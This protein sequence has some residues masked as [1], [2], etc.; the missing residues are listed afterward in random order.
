MA[1]LPLASPVG[2]DF[3]SMIVG[4]VLLIIGVLALG[5]IVIYAKKRYLQSR[6]EEDAASGGLTIEELEQMRQSGKISTEEFSLLRKRALGLDTP[7]DKKPAVSSSDPGGAV[8]DRGSE[9]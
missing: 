8:D 3:T 5:M 6:R 9:G 1:V 2:L 7:Y 4:F